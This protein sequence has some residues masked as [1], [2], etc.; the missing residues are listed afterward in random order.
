MILNG[1]IW[2][3]LASLSETCSSL[4]GLLGRDLSYFPSKS[5]CWTSLFLTYLSGYIF[6]ECKNVG[7]MPKNWK[8][9]AI[10]QSD[11]CQMCFNYRLW[12]SM[13]NTY[14]SFWWVYPSQHR[15]LNL[16]RWCRRGPSCTSG[17]A[18][19]CCLDQFLRPKWPMTW[20]IHRSPA[21]T[22]FDRRRRS[23]VV[24]RFARTIWACSC[25][26]APY[27]FWWHPIRWQSLCWCWAAGNQKNIEITW[28]K[29]VFYW[30]LFKFVVFWNHY[31]EHRWARIKLWDL[32]TPISLVAVASWA[33]SWLVD[34]VFCTIG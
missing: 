28:N 23:F 26:W 31:I 20:V 12:Q 19:Q 18:V 24:I 33:C 22:T 16:H 4:L 17:I 13:F 2:M 25:W 32:K 34:T 8:T 1:W 27:S 10:C 11:M 9:L 7:N 6:K 30:L 3:N 21:I 5:R 15:N 14:A 29:Y